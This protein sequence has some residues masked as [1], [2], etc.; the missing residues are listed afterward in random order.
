MD[1]ERAWIGVA[2]EAY[3]SEPGPLEK[4]AGRLLPSPGLARALVNTPSLLFSWVIASAAIL[5]AG[6]SRPLSPA[7]RGSGSSPRR[8]WASVSPSPTGPA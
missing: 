4:L 6:A 3:S 5:A 2:A 7:T 8:S 1:L